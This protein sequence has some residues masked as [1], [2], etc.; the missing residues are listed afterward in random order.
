MLCC[1]AETQYAHVPV[2]SFYCWPIR[3]VLL[4]FE[5][6]HR[7]HIRRVRGKHYPESR[8]GPDLLEVVEPFVQSRQPSRHQVHVVQHDPM[9]LQCVKHCASRQAT[10]LGTDV[11]KQIVKAP[12]CCNHVR[13]AKWKPRDGTVPNVSS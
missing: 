10:P 8:V 9:T 7:N 2:R 4:P 6:P 13:H 11:Q 12:A 5:N 3:F 1:A